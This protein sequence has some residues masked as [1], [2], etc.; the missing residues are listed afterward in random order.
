MDITPSSEKVHQITEVCLKHFN[1]TILRLRSIF[2]VEDVFDSL[3][4]IFLLFQMYPLINLSTKNHISYFPFRTVLIWLLPPYLRRK[5][6]QRT[7]FNNT[8]LHWRLLA[9]KI[10]WHV[11][12]ANRLILGTCHESSTNGPGDVSLERCYEVKSIILIVSY[13]F[14]AA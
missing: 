3:K 6:V 8:C 9:T 5:L 4:V 13:N 10:V 1:S 12:G 11:Q 7:H 14:L 2:L